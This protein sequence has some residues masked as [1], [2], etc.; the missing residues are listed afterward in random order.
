MFYYSIPCTMTILTVG[1]LRR[2]RGAFK[3][4]FF[5]IVYIP[6]PHQ[7]AGIY[8]PYIR[9][10]AFYT[11]GIPNCKSIVVSNGKNNSVWIYRIQIFFGHSRGSITVGT[12]MVIPVLGGQ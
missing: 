12:I 3:S 11:L 9:A 2:Y 8:R 10:I 1:Q 7:Q 4:G 6:V 5:H